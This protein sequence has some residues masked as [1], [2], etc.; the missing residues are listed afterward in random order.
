MRAGLADRLARTGTQ[1]AL[2]GGDLVGAR[3]WADRISDTFWAPVSVSRVELE[4]GRRSEAVLLLDQAVPRCERH[5]VVLGLLR[6]CAHE[7]DEAA[8]YAE[9]ALELAVANEMLQTVASNSAAT[10]DLIERAAWRVPAAWMTRLRRQLA[11]GGSRPPTHSRELVEQLTD[12]ERDVLRYLPSRLT[13]REI[14]NELY[15]SVNTLKFHLKVIYRK[16]GV[17]SRAEAAAKARE[18]LMK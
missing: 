8:K 5:E 7:G 17:T 16:L 3:E 14:A 2:A 6:A 12:R 13:V 1:V 18:L 9:T 4:A 10:V 11:A 15:V